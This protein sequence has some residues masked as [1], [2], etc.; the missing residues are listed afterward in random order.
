[1]TDIPED[2]DW[3][4][5]EGTWEDQPQRPLRRGDVQSLRDALADLWIDYGGEG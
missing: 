4:D 5:E 2:D 3:E 1:M